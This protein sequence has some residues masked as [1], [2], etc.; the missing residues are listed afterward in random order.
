M[1]NETKTLFFVIGRPRSGTTLLRTMLDAH[2][3]IIV[4]PEYPVLLKLINTQAKI[5]HWNQKRLH[6][7]FKTL[8][9]KQLF[10]FWSW[11][12]LQINDGQFYA[13][14]MNQ[15]GNIHF[16]DIFKTF[17]A[18]TG[19][20]FTKNEIKALGDK[21]PVYALYIALLFKRFPGAKFIFII[22]DYRDQIVSMQ[23]FR[24]EA[25]IPSLLA[26]RWKAINKLLLK[27][28]K[29]H[30]GRSILIKYEDLV[31]DPEKWTKAICRFLGVA[32]STSVMEFYQKVDAM[33]QS[34]PD[35]MFEKY[36]ASLTRP[37]NQDTVGLWKKSMDVSAIKAAECVAG[38]FGEQLGYV[39]VNKKFGIYLRFNAVFWSLYGFILY[40]TMFYG[41]FLPAWLRNTFD[42]ILPK[43]VNVY[44]SLS[45]HKKLDKL[46]KD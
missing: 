45:S 37:I 14:L 32:H 35:G 24:F 34:L 33:K 16:E 4:P 17:I 44:Y 20:L 39:P 5:K 2:P 13:S 11:H 36:H 8:K 27:L 18:H 1:K 23:K 12:L 28:Y 6:R 29:Q 19:S 40:K 41:I 10:D 15:T 9:E 25:P 21:N 38:N 30:P 31:E 22:R 7:L 43:L 26:Y 3:N 42:N 46:Q